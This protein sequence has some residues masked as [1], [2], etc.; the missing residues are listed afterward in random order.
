VGI[1]TGKRGNAKLEK[2]LQSHSVPQRTTVVRRG[3]RRY[4]ATGPRGRREYGMRWGLGRTDKGVKNK[5]GGT[6]MSR[7]AN[8]ATVRGRMKR[9]PATQL[10]AGK[11]KNLPRK[12]KRNGFF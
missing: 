7:K 4:L 11:K 9:R 1:Q 8:E 5:R 3:P 12:G 6:K 2:K 10:A